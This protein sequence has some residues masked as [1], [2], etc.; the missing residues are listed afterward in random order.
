MNLSLEEVKNLRNQ[1]ETSAFLLL[2]ITQNPHLK[3][4]LFYIF[5]F[6][7]IVT[8]IGNVGIYLVI[9]FSSSLHTPMYN[10]LSHLSFIDL[11]YASS[12]VPNTMYNLRKQKGYISS[13]GCA[14]QLFMFS[15]FGSTECLLFGV[16]AYDRYVAICHPL[17]YGTIMTVQACTLFVAASY[18][19][20]VVQ[21]AIQTGCTFSLSFCGTHIINHFI[22]DALPL[23]RLSC[24]STFINKL[25]IS[26]CATLIGGGSLVIILISYISIVATVVKIPSSKGKKRAFSTCASHLLC[27]T[28]F[29]GTVLFNYLYPSSGIL[30]RHEIVASVLYTMV[31]PMLNPI[32]YSLRNREVRQNMQQFFSQQLIVNLWFINF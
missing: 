3:H 18:F 6:M 21:A 26:I 13:L 7:Y 17:H 19:A 10:F 25:L 29:Y 20:A 5:L 8:L 27:V 11:C 14:M 30:T 16:M 12:I 1:S 2:G 4:V 28:L 31:I 22:C 15:S 9:Q 24:S 32:I 23:I